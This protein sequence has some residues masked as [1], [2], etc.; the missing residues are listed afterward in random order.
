MSHIEKKRSLV[1]EFSWRKGKQRKEGGV[2]CWVEIREK[3]VRTK[4][5]GRKWS[6]WEEAP[7]WLFVGKCTHHGWARRTPLHSN[8]S[9][10]SNKPL[11]S[12]SLVG[13]HCIE[14]MI[15]GSVYVYIV[16]MYT[17]DKDIIT[18]TLNAPIFIS[19]P[20]EKNRKY[21]CRREDLRGN[22]DRR[23]QGRGWGGR[24]GRDRP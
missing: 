5:T 18:E 17:H 21:T 6:K 23:S 13:Q 4:E 12:T 19:V 15:K 2:C 14:S 9:P 11:K 20:N 22:G 24:G 8:K 3:W 10:L 1:R 16:Y 7:F